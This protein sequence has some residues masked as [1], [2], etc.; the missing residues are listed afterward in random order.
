[1]QR[2]YEGKVTDLTAELSRTRARMIDIIDEK[3]K[4]ENELHGIKL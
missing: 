3:T 4:L 1:M 2:Q